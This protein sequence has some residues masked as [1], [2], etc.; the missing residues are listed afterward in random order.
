MF[1]TDKNSD[2]PCRCQLHALC[3]CYT[4]LHER[5]NDAT[6]S[7]IARNEVNLHFRIY[8][9]VAPILHVGFLCSYLRFSTQTQVLKISTCGQPC[10]SWVAK[11]RDHTKAN[12][13]ENNLWSLDTT[14]VRL[15]KNLRLLVDKFE[16]DQSD[17]KSTQA[18]HRK[19]TQAIASTRKFWTSRLTRTLS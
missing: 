5:R 3:L 17:S 18:Q 16:L 13:T 10:V 4:S 2:N 12:N 14:S 7:A 9:F 8:I 15:V 19:Y 1:A 11:A 6:I